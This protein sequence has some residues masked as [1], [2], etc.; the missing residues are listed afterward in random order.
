MDF[1]YIRRKCEDTSLCVREIQFCWRFFWYSWSFRRSR[2]QIARL[3]PQD[4]AGW[5]ISAATAMRASTVIR[6]TTVTIIRS[7]MASMPSTA[8]G[9]IAAITPAICSVGYG[10]Q[11]AGDEE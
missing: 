4:S 2:L 3:L 10:P 11:G 7:D 6:L 5:P 9:F 1:R 8:H